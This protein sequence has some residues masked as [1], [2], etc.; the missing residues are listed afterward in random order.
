MEYL[1]IRRNSISPNLLAWTLASAP[2]LR[3]VVWDGQA[4]P[5]NCSEIRSL[6]HINIEGAIDYLDLLVDVIQASQSL[7]TLSVT[8]TV[9][10]DDDVAEQ[11]RIGWPDESHPPV[12]PRLRDIN[13]IGFQSPAAIGCVLK[14]IRA[15]NVTTLRMFET[16]SGVHQA[17][18]EVVRAITTYHGEESILASM[19][20][21]ASPLA[22]LELRCSGEVMGLELDDPDRD[23]FCRLEFSLLRADWPESAAMIAAVLRDVDVTLSLNTLLYD[24]GAG[25]YKSRYAS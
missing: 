16:H 23:L 1:K 11:Q 14:S 6:V 21:N 20:R 5:W 12:L 19:L 10:N 25:V 13:I 18:D 8:D 15:P 4:L 22:K 24:E 17:G 2:K 7:E 3:T 9:F